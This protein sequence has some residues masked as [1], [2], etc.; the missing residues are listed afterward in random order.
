VFISFILTAG[1]TLLISV[2][3]F[4]LGLVHDPNK[5]SQCFLDKKFRCLTKGLALT[6]QKD[7]KSWCDR[8][9]WQE[10]VRRLVVGFSDTQ[11]LTGGAI[12]LTTFIRLGYDRGQLSVYHFSVVSDLV[13]LSYSTHLL[14]LIVLQPYFRENS[15]LRNIRVFLMCLVGL[16]MVALSVMTAH[17]KSYTL[18]DC[19]ALCLIKELPSNIGGA[20]KRWM[21]VNV[22]FICY[23]YPCAILSLF[24]FREK[25]LPFPNRGFEIDDS[26][27]RKTLKVLFF[28][29]YDIMW[30]DVVAVSLFAWF[31][32]GV[33]KLSKI[34]IKDS[35]SFS[36]GSKMVVK[37]DR[38]RTIG[39]LVNSSQ[40]FCFRWWFGS[41]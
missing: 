7:A 23:D 10:I 19:P 29:A 40:C 1:F 31:I 2:L 17:R 20:P 5:G 12:L 33:V 37:V 21:I 35:I 41:E 3:A 26:I 15:N 13:W 22:L 6:D 18:F 24:P 28:I 9:F 34:E 38:T 16:G 39:V 36:E 27:L 25:R 8:E 32:I 14:T 11:I 4:L 30:S